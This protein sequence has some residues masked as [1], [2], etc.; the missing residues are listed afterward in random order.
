MITV[1]QL[2]QYVRWQSYIISPI[3]A[4]RATAS[5][6]TNSKAIM[7]NICRRQ[8]CFCSDFDLCSNASLEM[9]VSSVM[10]HYTKCVSMS[11][12]WLL[13][14][15][16]SPSRRICEDQVCCTYTRRF[17]ITNKEICCCHWYTVCCFK[18]KKRDLYTCNVGREWWKMSERLLRHPNLNSP[19]PGLSGSSLRLLRQFGGGISKGEP[20]E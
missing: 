12:H 16:V 14:L 5:L 10:G 15:N 17:L 20:I 9:C 8:R 1:A 2:S 6:K 19:T 11:Y 4:C 18:Q 7:G 3:M 13:R